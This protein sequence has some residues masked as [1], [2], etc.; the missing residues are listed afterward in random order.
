MLARF[1][2]VVAEAVLVVDCA[3]V[4]EGSGAVENEDFGGGFGCEGGGEFF[5]VVGDV[6]AFETGLAAGG[7]GLLHGFGGF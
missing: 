2:E 4:D 5:V 6:A 1:G 3:A 7:E